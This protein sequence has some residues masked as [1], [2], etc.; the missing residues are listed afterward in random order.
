MFFGGGGGLFVVVVFFG[1]GGGDW[2]RGGQGVYEGE[3][4]VRERDSAL[5]T[6]LY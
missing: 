5:K 2:R 6:S 4:E 1:G 3:K